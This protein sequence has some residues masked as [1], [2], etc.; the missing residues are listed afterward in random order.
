MDSTR[1]ISAMG[2]RAIA[3]SIAGALA[4]ALAPSASAEV[5]PCDAWEV[6][7]TVAANLELRDTPMGEGDGV[8]K[9]GPGAMTLR[10]E[11][12]G[13]KPGGAVKMLAYAMQ[14]RF[15]IVSK[16]LFW[17]TTVMTDTHTAATPDA[18]WIAAEGN[19]T[20]RTLRWSTP[21]RG[22]RTDGHIICDGSLCGKFGAPPSGRTEL[23]IGPGPVPF[24]AFAYGADMK[25]FTMPITFV[26]KTE[27]PKQTGFIALAARET[28]RA[29]VAVKPCK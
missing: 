28:R 4:L 18:C 10:F 26:S 9:I 2:K 14:E 12:R 21:V 19:L 15:Q 22:Y 20:D 6:E 16:T 23:H 8:Y 3:A 1:P 11:D 24:S 17:T 29:C 25:S 13:G 27:M 7:Y 5:V